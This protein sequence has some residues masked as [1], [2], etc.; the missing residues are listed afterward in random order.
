MH[1]FTK[2]VPR[3]VRAVRNVRGGSNDV[4]LPLTAPRLPMNRSITAHRLISFSSIPLAD[5][6]AVKNALGVTVNDVVLAVTAGALRSYLAGRDELPDKPLVASIPTSVRS[7]DDEQFGNKVSSMFAGLPVEVA[8]PIDRVNAVARSMTGAKQLHADVGDSTLED[9]AETAAPALFSRGMRFYTRLRV[10]ERLR[11]VINLI[12]SN[13]P[14]PPWPLYF[15]GAQLVAIHP[16]GPIFDDCGLNITVI[17]YLD[18]VDFGFLTC[19]EL[20]PDIDD[21]AHYVPDALSEL[22]KAAGV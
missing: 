2:S 17:S 19:R 1:A 8:D 4:A 13:V 11:P 15:A 6:K 10:A 20:M 16:L 12:L 5:V 14:G 21:V 18:H 9:W 3:V 7:A 22:M